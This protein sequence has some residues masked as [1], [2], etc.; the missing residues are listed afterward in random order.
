MIISQSNQRPQIIVDGRREAEINR[1]IPSL[2]AYLLVSGKSVIPSP[3]QTSSVPRVRRYK[4][5][6]T[7]RGQVFRILRQICLIKNYNRFYGLISFQ[8]QSFVIISN[9]RKRDN[10]SLPLL[11]HPRDSPI[12]SSLQ[13]PTKLSHQ[14]K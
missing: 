4:L 12:F 13:D 11:R 7:V 2:S 10:F 1:L 14:T 5:E 9:L 8:I 3:Y 6:A